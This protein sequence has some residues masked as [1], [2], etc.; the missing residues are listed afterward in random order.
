MK[1][2]FS[3][4]RGDIF[5]GVTAG[6]VALPL[7][8]AFGVSSGLGP[9]AG[10]YGAIFI[11][12]FAALFG[13]TNTQ[14]SGPTAPMTAV[15]MVVIAGIIA[16]NDGDVNKALPAILTVFILAGLMQIGLGILGLG[17]YIRYIPYP[18]V[19]GFMT[20]I[21]VIILVTQILPSLG[22]YPKD[23][24]EFVESFKPVAEEL[25]LE[26][27]LKEEAG[28]GI[29]VLEDFKETIDRAEKVTPDQILKESQTL[30]A[31]DASGVVGALKALPRALQNINWLELILA[32]GT[33]FIIYG[34]KRITKAVPS[35]LVA[36]VV[37]TSIA[38]GFGLNYQPIERIPEGLPT[39]KTEIFTEFSLGSIAPYIF[40]ALTLALLGAIDSLLTSVVADNM[41]KTKHKP[42]KELVGQ[43]I[44][45]T[46]GALFGG[47]PGAGATIRT[48]VNINSGGKTKLSGMIAGVMLLVIL[49]ALAPLA[50][51]IPAAVL[52]GILIT[53]GIGVMDYKGLRAMPVLPKDVK[54]GPF[55]LSSEVIIMLVVLLLSTFWNL[56]YAVGVGLVIASLMF[57][58]KIGDLTAERSDVKPIKEE[59]WKDEIGFPESLKEEVFIKHLKGP[60][61]FGSTSEFQNLT[62]QIPD[63][64][65]TVIMRL[66]RMQYMDQSGLYAM[67]DML[68]DLK[69]KGVEVLFVNLLKQPRYM[70]ERID[71]IPDFIPEEHIFKNF[72]DCASWVKE[73]VEDKY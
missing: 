31:K 41:T 7:A 47:I 54:F 71:I 24:A 36:L 57:M 13:G 50:S 46:I 55:K 56:V 63:T 51:K 52:A 15:S 35:T 23:D 27:I 29:L 67:E 73:N 37:M 60:L 26:N 58:K 45:N 28:E 8:L 18:V 10:L 62:L 64:A 6:I 65:S 25:I 20:A 33:I 40:T 17:K 2:L 34:F 42:N 43:G 59:A 69:T 14:I 53:V 48:V 5:G 11:S 21:G 12:F 16:V 9:S 49:L 72:N 39:I 44:G 4:L 70:M 22:Y 66:G 3:N 32:L 19:S 68:Q 61:F 1:N 30:A 38:I